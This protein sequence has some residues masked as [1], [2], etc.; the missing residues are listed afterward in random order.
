MLIL[1][2]YIFLPYPSIHTHMYT[3]S[4]NSHG[5]WLVSLLSSALSSLSLPFWQKHNH[6][7]NNLKINSKYFIA[8]YYL[9]KID[10][11]TNKELI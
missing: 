10:L 9:T 3:H 6:S 5:N 7:W 11:Y 8:F 1:D 2:T 4:R